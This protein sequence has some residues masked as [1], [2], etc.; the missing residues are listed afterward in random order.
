MI[1]A[2]LQSLVEQQPGG[3]YRVDR[4]KVKAALSDLHVPIESEFAEFFLAYVITLFTS[5]VS[6]EQLCDIAEPT[7]QIVLG[8]RFVWE[9]WGLSEQF[10]CITAIQG[11]GAY[12]YDRKTGKVWDFELRTREEFLAEHQQARWGSFFEF[13]VWYLG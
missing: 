6:D 1:P 4:E 10:I 8:S 9:V 11:E 2:E 3:V 13:M 12:L 7:S 5:Q